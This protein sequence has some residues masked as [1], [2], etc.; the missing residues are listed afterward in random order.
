MYKA[1]VETTLDLPRKKVFDALVDFGGLEKV[2]PETIRSLELTGNGIG[3]ERT[4]QLTE[5]GTVVERL[6]VAH[7]DSIFGYTMIFNDALPINNYCAVVI[8]EDTGS[9]TIARW[10]SNWDVAEGSTD[11][12][13]KQLLE[14]LYTTLLDRMHLLV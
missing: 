12:E 8:L 10:G 13:V 2:L 5:G 3:A 14:G 11:G 1:L 7:D 4:I 6:D 9:G